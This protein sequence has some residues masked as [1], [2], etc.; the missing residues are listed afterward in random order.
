MIRLE[1][2]H[3]KGIGLYLLRTLS[4]CRRRSCLSDISHIHTAHFLRIRHDELHSCVHPVLLVRNVF[5]PAN[6]HKGRLAYRQA[7]LHCT[8]LVPDFDSDRAFSILGISYLFAIAV[9][10]ILKKTQKRL[11][12]LFLLHKKTAPLRTQLIEY[13]IDQPFTAPRAIPRMIYF[14]SAR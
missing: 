11:R 5:L 14:E 10:A 13:L 1:G 12:P 7:T 8:Q 3:E 9:S 6:E 4:C 2:E